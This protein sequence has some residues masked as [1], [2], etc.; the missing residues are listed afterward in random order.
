MSKRMPVLV[1]GAAGEIGSAS[2]A[3]VDLLLSKG[4]SVR[5]FVRKEDARAGALR[6]AGADVFVGDLLNAADVAA[7]LKACR[8]IYFSMSLSPYYTDASI[9]MAA[10]AKAQGDVE[11][12]VSISEFEQSYMTFEKMTKPREERLAWLGGL[13]TDWSPQQRAHWMTEQVLDWSGLPVVHIRATM[14]V[15]NPI[16]A[17]FPL[18]QL[19]ASGELHLPFGTQKIAPIASYDVA[20]L[21]AGILVNPGPHISKTYELT[22]PELKDMHGFAEDYAAALDRPVKYLPQDL[23]SWMERNIDQSLGTRDPHV[24]AHLRTITRLVASGRYAVVTDQLMVLL[25]RPPT[26]VREALQRHPRV[27]MALG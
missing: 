27:R 15:E 1:T 25:G 12:L 7:A 23:D 10:A 14:F 4:E 8:R 24:A 9:L 6:R 16:L 17:W 21:C 26:T 11:V 5:A 3:M 22:G 19:V 2:T 13:V 20:D 18:K